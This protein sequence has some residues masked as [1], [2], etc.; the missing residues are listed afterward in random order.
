MEV[1]GQLHASASLPQEIPR[2][3]LYRRMDGPQSRSVRYGEQK[4]LLTYQESNSD[5]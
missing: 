1:S 3:P 5:S 2:Y 4:N